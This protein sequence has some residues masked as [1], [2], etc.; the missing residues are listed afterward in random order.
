LPPL[1]IRPTLFPSNKSYLLN[2]AA[3][4]TADDVSTRIFILCHINLVAAIISSS[5]T[6]TISEIPFFII[7]NVLSPKNQKKIMYT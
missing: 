6:R 3:R 1:R 7:E 2:A 5:S 4:T